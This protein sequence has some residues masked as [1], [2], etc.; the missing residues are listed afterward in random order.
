MVTASEVTQTANK[1]F[2]E[3]L[4][5][6]GNVPGGIWLTTIISAVVAQM[7]YS[8]RKNELK[9]L[10]SDELAIQLGKPKDQV[11][12][13]D[14]DKLA[15]RN[16]T[17]REQLE[18]TKKERNVTF[19][20]IGTATVA[21]I[22]TAFT[23]MDMIATGGTISAATGFSLTNWLATTAVAMMAYGA[24]K[25]VLRKIGEKFFGIDQ[26]TTH[27]RIEKIFKDHVQGKVISRERVFDVFVHANPMLG[28][29]IEKEYGKSFDSLKPV[30]K[31]Q[32]AD[33]DIGKQLKVAELTEAIN[34]GKIK[35]T[36]LAFTVEGKFSGVEPT[37]GDKPKH[38]FIETVSEKAHNAA[39]K[40][41]ETAHHA[42]EK[43]E[44]MAEKFTGHHPADDKRPDFS[45]A[46]RERE[47]RAAQSQIQV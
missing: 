13:N 14:F 16:H 17:I 12:K 25:P 19:G 24:V 41:S 5:H 36:E 6:N 8:E 21:A 28:A 42:A 15:E 1:G 18:K 3:T 10:Y 46:E 32:L 33:S 47:R 45:F 20:V 23:I 34:Q 2:V 9:E 27:E 44:H 35:S 4:F 37:A 39:E 11:D 26:K 43:L 7:E 40:V 30:D 31:L 22:F 29:Y 38:S